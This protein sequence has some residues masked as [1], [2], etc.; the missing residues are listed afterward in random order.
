[1]ATAPAGLPGGAGRQARPW[2]LVLGL[3]AVVYGDIGTSPIHAPQGGVPRSESFARIRLAF[4]YVAD[5]KLPRLLALACRSGV[6]LDIMT[7][8]VF[9][10]RRFHKLSAN[11]RMPLWKE[12]GSWRWPPERATPP[13]CPRTG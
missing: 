8:S 9:P 4:G 2:K 7:T 1:M 6:K 12:P 13:T 10:R 11:S 5:P 3:I